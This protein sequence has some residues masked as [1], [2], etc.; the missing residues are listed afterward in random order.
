MVSVPKI[1]KALT[2]T[3]VVGV[4]V[5]DFDPLSIDSFISRAMGASDPSKA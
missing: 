5:L 1:T 3:G 4:V 2:L